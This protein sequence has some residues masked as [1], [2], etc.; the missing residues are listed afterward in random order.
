M[1]LLSR[2]LLNTGAVTEKKKKEKWEICED[3][4]FIGQQ[5]HI[6]EKLLPFLM[7]NKKH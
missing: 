3:C 7:L 5:Y 4:P 1:A 6:F 2:L